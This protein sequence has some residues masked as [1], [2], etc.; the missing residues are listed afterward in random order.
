MRIQK[1]WKDHHGTIV[2]LTLLDPSRPAQTLPE[3][4]RT[5]TPSQTLQNLLTLSQTLRDH[6]GPKVPSRPS[7]TFQDP[8]N[9]K[10]PPRAYFTYPDSLRPSQLP[11]PLSPDSPRLVETLLALQF[12]QDPP[13]SS[14][15]IR[16]IICTLLRPFGPVLI[17]LDP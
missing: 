3:P 9:F 12:C 15:T 10:D 2:S 13:P 8:L 4:Q 11:R 7:E 14:R 17:L 6:L 1:V 5:S 16:L